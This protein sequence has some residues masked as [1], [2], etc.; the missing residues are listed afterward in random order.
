MVKV[1]KVAAWRIGGRYIEDA[2]E[3]E[4]EVRKLVIIEMLEDHPHKIW[5][6]ADEGATDN[7]ADWVAANWDE[8]ENR[9]KK[10]MAGT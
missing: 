2:K 5:E 7:V 8:I 6:D 9:V 10:A 1:V 3:A 4:R